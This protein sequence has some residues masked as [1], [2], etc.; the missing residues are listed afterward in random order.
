MFMLGQGAIEL[1][2][3][4]HNRQHQAE[5]GSKAAEIRHQQGDIDE[6]DSANPFYSARLALRAGPD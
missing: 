3:R 4:G 5:D 2:E 6:K 1:S